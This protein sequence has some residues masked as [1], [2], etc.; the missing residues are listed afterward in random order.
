MFSETPI[1]D[2][3]FSPR[4]NEYAM[5][6]RNHQSSCAVPQSIPQDG[7]ILKETR[8][9]TWSYTLLTSPPPVSDPPT[10]PLP[11]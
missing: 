5:Q 11:S 10:S 2:M 1:L 8:S 7:L 4:N 3:L 6:Y 9:N